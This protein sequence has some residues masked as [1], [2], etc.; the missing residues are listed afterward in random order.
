M[1]SFVALLRKMSDTVP[2]P[3][4]LVVD[5]LPAHKTMLVKTYTASTDGMLTLHFLPGYAPELNPDEFGMEP[6]ETHGR[7]PSAAATRRKATH[8]VEAQLAAIKRMPQLV[9]VILPSPNCRLYYRLVCNSASIASAVHASNNSFRRG[10]IFF[11]SSPRLRDCHGRASRE[12]GRAPGWKSPQI[13]FSA[14]GLFSASTFPA[15]PWRRL[16]HPF[17]CPHAPRTPEQNGLQGTGRIAAEL[18]PSG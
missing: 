17:R 4:H 5:G 6:H 3:V 14:G 11:S 10:V 16:R 18:R 15:A 13:F 7:G 1:P 9:P 8:Q 2:K 12:D